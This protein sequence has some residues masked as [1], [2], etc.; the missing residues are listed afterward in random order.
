MDYICI[1]CD[2]QCDN[3]FKYRNHCKKN[4]CKNKFEIDY[5]KSMFIA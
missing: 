3:I 1:V 4:N 5:T 2:K